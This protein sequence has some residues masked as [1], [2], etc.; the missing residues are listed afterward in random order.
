MT[1]GYE[2]IIIIIIIIGSTAFGGLGLLKKLC[3]FF[4]VEGDLL[5]ILIFFCFDQLLPSIAISVLQLF[6]LNLV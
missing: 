5:P 1:V 4:S 3:P 6:L 2:V